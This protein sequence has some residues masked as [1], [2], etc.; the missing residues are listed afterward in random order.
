MLFR[1]VGIPK[2]VHRERMKENMD[3]FDF[4]LD[5]EDMAAIR[6]L[7]TKKSPIYDEMDPQRALAIGRMK[8]HD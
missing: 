2:S 7:D 3:V 6:T 5:E 4:H 1:S 8:I